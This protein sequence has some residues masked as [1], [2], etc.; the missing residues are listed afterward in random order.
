MLNNNTFCIAPWIQ[1][2]MRSNGKLNPCCLMST[3]Q[4]NIKIDN[5]QTYYHSER[6]TNL[7]ANMLAGVPSNEC[8]ACYRSEQQYDTSMRTEMNRDYKFIN[9]KYYEKTLGYFGYDKLNIPI[10]LEIHVG[11]IC[12]LKCLTCNPADSSAFLTEDKI[13][14]I[15]DGNQRDYTIDN[16]YLTSI[17]N[18]LRT[19]RVDILDLRGG[20]SMLESK[21]QALL[22]E[23]EIDITKK[24]KLRV[25]TNGTVFDK[26]W[27]AILHKFQSAEIMLSIDGYGSDNEYIR[28]PSKW[29][30]II[31]TYT[32]LTNISTIENL[33]V[34]VTV[35][36]LNLPIL[37]K[38]FDWLI[39]N[40]IYFK[41]SPL[42]YPDYYNL[43][44]LPNQL[45]KEYVTNLKQYQNK[46]NSTD[47][48]NQELGGI[49]SHIDSHLSTATLNNHIWQE[50]CNMISIRDKHR[51]NSIFNI[52]P[53]LREYWHAE[54]N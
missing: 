17:I 26:K 1:V 49:I 5:L 6:I 39:S 7:R 8:N 40:Q 45:L 33:F 19:N 31:E 22:T 9:S 4:Q 24:I 25:Q 54:N 41:L 51:N 30:D 44:N 13:L 16:E 11:N 37:P 36:N 29:N 52:N 27:A 47:T 35:S 15:S 28:Y 53:Q 46:F 2:V 14:K 18:Q 21:V 20:E 42:T 48:I 23:L 32:Q 3:D 12:N 38:L 34:N 10:R 43:L 50:F